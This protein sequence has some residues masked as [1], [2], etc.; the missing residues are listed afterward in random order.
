[1][2]RG[3]RGEIVKIG[4]SKPQKGTLSFRGEMGSLEREKQNKS[5]PFLGSRKKIN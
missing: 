3:E 1:M 5:E 4:A 2:N